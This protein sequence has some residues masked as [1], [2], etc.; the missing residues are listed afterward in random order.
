MLGRAVGVVLVVVL[1]GGAIAELARHS[2]PPPSHTAVTQPARPATDEPREGLFVGPPSER[3]AEVRASE[4]ATNGMLGALGESQ[5][6][7]ASSAP[8]LGLAAIAAAAGAWLTA[9]MIAKATAAL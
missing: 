7:A 6:R 2:E 8:V 4:T 9:R 3:R 1:V 5:S